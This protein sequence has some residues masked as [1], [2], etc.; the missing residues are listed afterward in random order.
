M[1]KHKDCPHCEGKETVSFHSEKPE[2][3]VPMGYN[4]SSFHCSLCDISVTAETDEE[5]LWDDFIHIQ[6]SFCF[7][8]AWK[9]CGSSQ[10]PIPFFVP[11]YET[12]VAVGRG[13]LVRLLRRLL[14]N[15]KLLDIMV[16]EM[17]HT[18]NSSL[19]NLRQRI[20]R[21]ALRKYDPNEDHPLRIQSYRLN[22]QV[23]SPEVG[24]CITHIPTGISA[25]CQ[26]T[27]TRSLNETYARAALIAKL[28]E[29]QA[30]LKEEDGN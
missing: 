25:Q 5:S 16:F 7:L 27:K 1:S 22:T 23:T 30:K 10:H 15:V 11:G 14:L 26:E 18:M 21:D 28:L 24:V 12:S 2:D 9:G 29:Q 19:G 6:D 20:Q 13:E 17:K 8:V 4:P 3:L